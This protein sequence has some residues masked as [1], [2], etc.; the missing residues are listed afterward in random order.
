MG[1]TL[2]GFSQADASNVFGWHLLRSKPSFRACGMRRRIYQDTL[3][4]FGS[5]LYRV[6]PY[7]WAPISRNP[8]LPASVKRVFART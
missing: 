2:S 1:L 7:S 3:S 4:D 6:N 5:D 8:K